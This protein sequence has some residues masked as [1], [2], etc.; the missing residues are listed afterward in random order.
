[1][2]TRSERPGASQ[3]AIRESASTSVVR[4]LSNQL[5]EGDCC[6]GVVD[7]KKDSNSARGG[8]STGGTPVAYWNKPQ[9]Y[10]I[11]RLYSEQ[12][13]SRE[14]GGADGSKGGWLPSG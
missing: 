11:M 13:E 14:R 3:D 4:I 8:G 6:D 12:N 9:I 2:N 10:S 5:K 7:A 1:M